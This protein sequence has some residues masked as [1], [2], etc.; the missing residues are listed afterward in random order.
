MRID[1]NVA[2]VQRDQLARAHTR[3]V[4]DFQNRPVAQT[5]GLRRVGGLEQVRHRVLAQKLGQRRLPL[6]RPNRLRGGRR[7]QAASLEEA[8]ERAE[9]RHL[10][11]DRGSRQPSL[12][13]QV[14]QKRPDLCRLDLSDAARSV[15]FHRPRREL[16]QVFG[17]GFD[18]MR[19]CRA[20][21][22]EMPDE[23]LDFSVHRLCLYRTT[24]LSFLTQTVSFIHRSG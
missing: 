6:R 21:G 12:R 19:A 2:D 17:V 8:K 15:R 18:G 14:R 22:A 16:H 3:R 23:V 9:R 4:E 11:R 13:R 10:P 20:D 1:G 5:V 7:N 24:R